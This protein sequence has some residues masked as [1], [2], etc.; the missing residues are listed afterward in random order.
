[1]WQTFPIQVEGG[2]VTNVA[3]IQL[4][5]K[6]PGAAQRLVNFES[7]VKGGYRRINGF[8]KWSPNL[9]PASNAESHI[10]GVS[11]FNGTAIA[12]R[13]GSIYGSTGGAW[14]T[15]ASG[16][17][18]GPKH[19]YTKFNFNGTTKLLGVDSL[20]YP[21][22]WDGTTF[23]NLTGNTDIQGASHAIEFKDHMFYA[24]GS[25]V[26]FSEPFQENQFDPGDGAGSFRVDGDVTGFAVFRERLFVFTANK[27]SALSGSSVADF[28]LTSVAEDIG[29]LYP[30]TIQEVGGDIMFLAADGLRLL[31]S[32]DRN[33]DFA[34]NV[35]SKPIQS[36]VTRLLREYASFTSIT[37]RG[38]SQYRL[39]CYLPGRPWQL[40]E[41]LIAT[42]TLKAQNADNPEGFEWSFT[43]GI[44][45]FVAYS[46]L[47][48]GVE[49]ILSAGVCNSSGQLGY[50]YRL[51]SSSSFDGVSIKSSY[52][53]P[54][55]TFN[56]PTIR[57]T[58]YRLTMHVT[59]EGTF[60]GL[61]AVDFDQGVPGRVQPSVRNFNN[62]GGGA[63]TWGSS[64][65]VWGSFS[66][67]NPPD[68]EIRI[69]LIGSGR[70]ASLQF[71]FNNG[72][73]FTIDTILLE[74]GINERR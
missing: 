20:N 17:T 38:K 68:T 5:M 58:L 52:W 19:R 60:S 11:F 73:P 64:G 71:E 1:M 6:M 29:C 47:Y 13:E 22:T 28:V 9:V 35:A 53:T 37:V 50:V 65:A 39:M 36:D 74:F 54:Y 40:S 25:L 42:Q 62:S 10:L 27:I 59:P 69:Q 66:Y 46:E 33:D 32:T 43:Q 18:H 48:N 56:D 63:L 21:Y 16:R 14:S 26:T 23:T 49:Y 51:E 55:Y 44:K 57:K 8:T 34:N 72:D 7:S 12:V 41:G 3:P 15:I 67:A 4:G 45:S 30:D 24:K 61:V 31:G 70:N 2:L